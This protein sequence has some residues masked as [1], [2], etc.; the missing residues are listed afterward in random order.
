[1]TSVA[2]VL[3]W[4]PPLIAVWKWSE[5]QHPRD[6]GGRF[7]HER[8]GGV[9][10]IAIHPD[11]GKLVAQTQRRYVS[12]LD[13]ETRKALEDYTRYT[14]EMEEL[15]HALRFERG[16]MQPALQALNTQLHRVIANAPS[17]PKP[18]TVWRGVDTT[19]AP[20]RMKTGDRIQLKGY[21]ST[22]LDPEQAFTRAWASANVDPEQAWTPKAKVPHPPIVFRIRATQGLDLRSVSILPNEQEILLGTHET[23]MVRKIQHNVTFIPSRN[24]DHTPITAT[25]IDLDQ[26]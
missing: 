19:G 13:A 4:D 5:A 6:Q 10:T 11:E 18:V 9:A 23:Y 3:K 2:T 7:T 14:P 16:P 26:Q 25:V 17:F 12:R 15:N 24:F 20:P 8:F 21:Q 22:S 1:M